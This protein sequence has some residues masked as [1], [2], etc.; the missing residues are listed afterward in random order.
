MAPNRPDLRFCNWIIPR[1]IVQPG[2]NLMPV[3][4]SRHYAIFL[5]QHWGK[6]CG[7]PY[8]ASQL[9]YSIAVGWLRY[10]NSTGIIRFC[11]SAPRSDHSDDSGCAVA[12]GCLA[13]FTGGFRMAFCCLIAAG[14]TL[15]S[16]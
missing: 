4:V 8:A 15:A 10:S 9:C 11:C 5:M 3:S 1:K 14:S 16:T 12:S 2:T 6:A 13:S 7:V